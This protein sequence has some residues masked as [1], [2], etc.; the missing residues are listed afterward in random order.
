MYEESGGDIEENADDDSGEELKR[1]L[2]GR[3]R[4]Y[5]LKA[6]PPSVP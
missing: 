3:E 1:Y 5:V 6:I 4:L 2:N